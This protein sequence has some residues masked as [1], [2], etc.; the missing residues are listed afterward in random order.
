MSNYNRGD[1][2]YKF[3]SKLIDNCLLQCRIILLFLLLLSFASN[4]PDLEAY[5]HALVHVL[6]G[7]FNLSF[8]RKTNCI[9]CKVI[10]FL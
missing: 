2:K 9:S 6:E 4:M 8:T 3:K 10:K 1:G 7:P 5:A